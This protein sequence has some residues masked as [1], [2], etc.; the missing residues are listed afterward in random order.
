[1]RIRCLLKGAFRLLVGE[2]VVPNDPFSLQPNDNPTNDMILF[3]PTKCQPNDPFLSNQKMP[4]NL[5]NPMILF[6]PT[7]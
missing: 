5:A 2:R 6:S 7:K 3:S 4:T 1:V